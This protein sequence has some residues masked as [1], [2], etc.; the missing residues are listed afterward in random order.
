MNVSKLISG[1]SSILVLSACG[2]STNSNFKGGVAVDDT[3]SFFDT[4]SNAISN[5]KAFAFDSTD[6]AITSPTGTIN[7][8]PNTIFL[9]T[10]NGPLDTSGGTTTLITGG[11]MTLEDVGASYVARLTAS[12]NG[13][14][15]IVG[16]VGVPTDPSSMPNSSATYNGD[17][18]FLL[19]DGTTT[20]DMT[21]SATVS[22]DFANGLVD[23]AVAS[24][25][26]EKSDGLTAPVAVFDLGSM[27][28]TGASI[29]GTDFGGG[30][31]TM[32]ST[33][34][35][36]LP[37]APIQN[38]MIG[39]FYGPEAREVGGIISVDGSSNGEVVVIGDFIAN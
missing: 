20:F 27:S 24:M 13:A 19:I 15:P 17:T 38:G 26:G 12:P 5:I 31:F 28:I 35:S 1:L 36:N 10:L 22:A 2:T 9:G 3:V 16:V 7:R 32:T 29:N 39:G 30:T 4:S 23:L 8:Q 34:I 21:G 25:N 18:Q 14:N 6:I 37:A 11:T 33:Q